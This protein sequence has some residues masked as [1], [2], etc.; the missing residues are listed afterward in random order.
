MAGLS[1]NPIPDLVV[2]P[3]L[4]TWSMLTLS[5]F[6]LPFF[7]FWLFQGFDSKL[8]ISTVMKGHFEKVSVPD[9]YLCCLFDSDKLDQSY[10]LNIC[11]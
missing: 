4:G 7:F 10:V 1:Q 6:F 11:L 9:G 3:I 8:F 5:L 2:Q